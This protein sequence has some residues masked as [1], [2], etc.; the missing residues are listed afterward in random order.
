MFGACMPVA[1]FE[2]PALSELVVKGRT[3]MTFT[4]TEELAEQILDWF[5]GFPT[6]GQSRRKSYFTKIK[7]DN[8]VRW[9][10]YWRAKALPHLLKLVD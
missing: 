4:N 9:R 10:P 3:G 7:H 5:R 6:K 2:F 1:A 8:A